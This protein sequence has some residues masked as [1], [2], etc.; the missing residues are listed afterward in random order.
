MP[1]INK[2]MRAAQR[3]KKFNIYFK[4]VNTGHVLRKALFSSM[5]EMFY[6]QLATS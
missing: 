3:F 2:T 4:L 1:T 6:N 5:K